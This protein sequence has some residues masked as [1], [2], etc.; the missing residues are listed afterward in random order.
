MSVQGKPYLVVLGI[1]QDGG[2]PQAGSKEH[3]GWRDPAFRRLVTCLGL[4]DPNTSARW[5]I[6]CTPDFAEQL[7]ILDELAPVDRVPGL[8]GIFLTHAH[9]GHYTGLIHLGRESMEA[10]GVPVYAMPRMCD[11]LKENGPWS[12]LIQN[13][14]I[15]LRPL[16]DRV[17][18]ELTL[19]L[20][21]EPLLVPHRQEYSETVG[22][23]IRG[24]NRSVLFIPDIDSWEDWERQGVYLEETI[25][26][27]D[28]AYLDGTFYTQHEVLG[29]NASAFPHPC[30]R[31]TMERL[32]SLPAEERRKIRFIHLNHTNPALAAGSEALKSIEGS[33]FGVA[34]ETE[35]TD[36]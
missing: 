20:S 14:N 24:P 28:L 18:V 9:M 19:G 33:G 35:R 15:E 17:E 29:R 10:R 32:G 31:D 13:E 34:G 21:L 30:I 25:A 5:M 6:E 26:Q 36:L 16:K 2:V 3:R 11:Y 7:H 1:A 27:V 22:C 23:R 4:V 8:E 12:Q